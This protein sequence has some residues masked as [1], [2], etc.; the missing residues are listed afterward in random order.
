MSTTQT[1]TA[2]LPVVVAHAA[3]AP[4]SGRWNWETGSSQA[5]PLSTAAESIRSGSAYSTSAA[6]GGSQVHDAP[7][8]L[9][10]PSR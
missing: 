3:G 2:L 9:S 4:T 5:T 10:V 6:G 1:E 7:A 8:G